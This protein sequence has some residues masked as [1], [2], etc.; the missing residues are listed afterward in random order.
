MIPTRQS[1]EWNN[2]VKCDS[3]DRSLGQ[4]GEN[5]LEMA[6]R[7]KGKIRYGKEEI[8]KGML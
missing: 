4:G 1:G 6:V 7:I 8:L 2:L 5:Y 3:S